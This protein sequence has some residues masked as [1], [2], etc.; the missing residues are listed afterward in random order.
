MYSQIDA[1]NR[2]DWLK[3]HGF[4]VLRFWNHD[5]FQQTPS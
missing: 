1:T 4:N 5:T 2:P 3:T